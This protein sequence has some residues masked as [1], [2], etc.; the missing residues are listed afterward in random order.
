MMHA[1]AI[2]AMPLGGMASGGFRQ[3]A[4]AVL[5]RGLRAYRCHK[6]EQE[7]MRASDEMLKD[8]GITRS[9]IAGAVWFGVEDDTRRWR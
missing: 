8:I 2:K 3:M 1:R 4:M 5:N 6:A 9:E 7:L